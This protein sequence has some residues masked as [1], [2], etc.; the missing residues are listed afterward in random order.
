MLFVCNHAAVHTMPLHCRKVHF[1]HYCPL[2]LLPCDFLKFYNSLNR[3]ISS[4]A[5]VASQRHFVESDSTSNRSDVMTQRFDSDPLSIEDSTMNVAVHGEL[6][7]LHKHDEDE[8]NQSPTTD[9]AHSEGLTS[10]GERQAHMFLTERTTNLNRKDG[11]EVSDSALAASVPTHRLPAV[12][13]PQVDRS[14]LPPPAPVHSIISSKDRAAVL[15]GKDIPLGRAVNFS[16]VAR[17][18]MRIRHNRQ[19]NV[20]RAAYEK[21]TT[22]ALAAMSITSPSA[23]G[24][25]LDTQQP[26][27]HSVTSPKDAASMSPLSSNCTSP[28]PRARPPVH[29]LQDAVRAFT[30]SSA[31]SFLGEGQGALFCLFGCLE[32]RLQLQAFVDLCRR[33]PEV[34]CFIGRVLQI[35]NV[36]PPDFQLLVFI[37]NP[38]LAPSEDFFNFPMVSWPLTT[39]LL[40]A[41]FYVTAS[42]VGYAHL[43]D[44]LQQGGITTVGKGIF[45]SLAVAESKTDDELIRNTSR[46]YRAAF[47]AG[48]CCQ[49]R[50]ESLAELTASCPRKSFSLLLVNIPMSTLHLLVEQVNHLDVTKELHEAPLS[51]VQ[52]GR[53]ISQ[54]SAVV[55]GHPVDLMRLDILIVQFAHENGVKIHRDF[56]FSECPNNSRFYCRELQYELIQIWLDMEYSVEGS[57]FVI[58]LFSPT[59][60]IDWSTSGNLTRELAGAVMCAQQDLTYALQNMRDGDV[61]LDFS[62]SSMRI[63]QM[64]AWTRRSIVC[65]AQPSDRV[66]ESI[67]PSPRRSGQDASVLRTLAKVSMLNE[68]MGTFSWE[69]KPLG[70][71]VSHL[72]TS[73]IDL[74]LLIDLDSVALVSPNSNSKTGRDGGMSITSFPLSL[75]GPPASRSTHGSNTSPSSAALTVG[76]MGSMPLVGPNSSLAT[77]PFRAAIPRTAAVASGKLVSVGSAVNKQ[78]VNVYEVSP[79][80]KYLEMQYRCVLTKGAVEFAERLSKATNL[81]F[82]SYTLLMCPT[83]FQLLEFWDG[84][85][86]VLKLKA[87]ESERRELRKVNK[88]APPGV[89]LQHGG[90]VNRRSFQM[91]RAAELLYQ[92]NSPMPH[93]VPI[94]PIQPSTS[95]PSRQKHGERAAW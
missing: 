8:C 39:L 5:R 93:A 54:R 22:F 43:V 68:A 69:L 88:D 19:G 81:D 85:E 62:T 35:D 41:S 4:A 53:V 76:R 57:E 7:Q 65:L 66:E 29:C 13:I 77:N 44:L 64:I 3:Q 79:L 72:S 34:E 18:D 11:L 71:R 95:N 1:E 16:R 2:L 94:P 70:A 45:A 49:K 87:A 86:F 78:V 74:R 82:P 42:K 40:A 32:R 10:L 26:L 17:D 59:N 89:Q 21:E 61:L 80:I 12:L 27:D 20:R 33:H 6:L 28:Q 63:G 15:G 75:T 55:V 58:P 56:L 52:I 25:S 38:A 46:Q 92:T 84:L 83:V 14:Q 51:E 48:I 36:F 9:L 91:K 31:S 50:L 90:A 24:L 47:C 67:L 37:K 60:G 30:S 73:F 23:G